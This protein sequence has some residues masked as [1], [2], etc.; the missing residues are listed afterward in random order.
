MSESPCELFKG[1]ISVTC[2]P[3]VCLGINPIRFQRQIFW[4]LVSLVLVPRVGVPD[5]WHKSV[6]PQG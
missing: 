1:G 5:M 4:E 2:R 3:I 6:A